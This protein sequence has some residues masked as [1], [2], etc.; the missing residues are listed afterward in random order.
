M[1]NKSLIIVSLDVL[2]HTTKTQWTSVFYT[3]LENIYSTPVNKGLFEAICIM[4]VYAGISTIHMNSI[5][6]HLRVIYNA[7]RI[8]KCMCSQSKSVVLYIEE[9][10]QNKYAM[11]MAFQLS[12]K[13]L[14]RMKTPT[15]TSASTSTAKTKNKR[16]ELFRFPRT[17]SNALIHTKFL[18][19]SPRK[20]PKRMRSRI[21]QQKRDKKH[22]QRFTD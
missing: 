21:S 7:W 3:L 14:T 5:Q 8:K 22:T 16:I 6:R 12:P 17:R 4:H 19:F 2:I 9:F 1:K 10:N 13:Q 18:E 20:I 15:T 11:P